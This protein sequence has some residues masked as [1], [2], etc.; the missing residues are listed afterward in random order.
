MIIPF[1]TTCLQSLF[2]H[3]DQAEQNKSLTIVNDD[4]N[5]N[6]DFLSDFGNY[7]ENN[8][9][10]KDQLIFVNNS[11]KQALLSSSGNVI[12]G[13]DGWMYYKGSILDYT[14]K[15]ALSDRALRNCAYNLSLMQKELE[16][17]G[18]KF[19]FICPP[20]KTEIYSQ[21]IPYNYIKSDQGSNY[22]RLIKYLDKFNVHYLDVKKILLEQDENLY[23]KTDTHWNSRGAAIIANKILNYFKKE[24]IAID[25]LDTVIHSNF[26]GDL[27]K[28]AFPSSSQ[29]E[30]DVYYR[31]IND[32]DGFK[33]QDWDYREGKSV[34][35]GTILTNSNA[36]EDNSI[37]VYRDSFSNALIP[38]LSSVYKNALYSKMIPYNTLL[39]EENNADCVVVERAERHISYL[40]ENFPLMNS[41]KCE[42]K[43]EDI[44]ISRMF[45]T[46]INH[47]NNG[48]FSII[49]GT[50]PSSLQCEDSEVFLR[51]ELNDGTTKTYKG[52]NNSWNVS[53]QIKD[54]ENENNTSKEVLNNGEQTDYGFS[55]CLNDDTIKGQN[56]K[57]SIIIK[58]KD[59]NSLLVSQN[60]TF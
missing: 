21:N 34:E 42:E 56:C 26:V 35:D 39:I 4:G 29:G 20:D 31:C 60:Y 37:V 9:T 2:D 23:L 33:G 7:F 43:L 59:K 19:L 54:S 17:A 22:D 6:V 1:L 53:S 12:F 28:M 32:E 49:K 50:I 48:P 15:T 52:F 5:L 51:I 27:Q 38:F 55:F 18:K 10:F 44:D 13:N 36:K 14:G 25:S 11:I 47:S 30:E 41:V 58:N 46:E 24:E 3:E 16:S 8:M 40:S 57:V 45:T